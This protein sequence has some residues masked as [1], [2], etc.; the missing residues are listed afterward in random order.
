M[1]AQRDDGFDFVAHTQRKEVEAMVERT[2]T[3]LRNEWKDAESRINDTCR[4]IEDKLD[5][6][7][8]RLEGRIDR[9]EGKLDKSRNWSVGLMVTMLA[10]MIVGFGV[11]IATVIS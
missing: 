8:D 6:G 4:R 5:G 7:I 9:L 11:V 10:T 3:R 1:M 2:E